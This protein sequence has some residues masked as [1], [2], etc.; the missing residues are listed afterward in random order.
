MVGFYLFL[1]LTKQI[2]IKSEE[3]FATHSIIWFKKFLILLE[4]VIFPPYFSIAVF[5]PYFFKFSLMEA[6]I[7]LIKN[8]DFANFEKELNQSTDDLK[9]L[10]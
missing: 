9:S 10:V 6:I 8:K 2:A 4:K 7:N 1:I 3:Y 5:P